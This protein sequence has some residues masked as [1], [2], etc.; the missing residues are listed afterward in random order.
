MAQL[1]A[2]AFRRAVAYER[3]VMN[4]YQ[5]ILAWINQ[6]CQ[7]AE[8]QY[9]ITLIPVT[10]T[11]SLGGITDPNTGLGYVDIFTLFNTKYPSAAPFYVANCLFGT[12]AWT[13]QQL[14]QSALG[15][16]AQ[17]TGTAFPSPL[18]PSVPQVPVAAPTTSPVG[19]LLGDGTAR[20]TNLA[21]SLYPIGAIT[22]QNGVPADSR[23][24]FV[25]AGIQTPFGT[26]LWWVLSSPPASAVGEYQ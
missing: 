5:Q 15:Y 9:G 26:A 2:A 14:L 4:I 6:A 25:E 13:P 21:G 7:E 12:F 18:P 23:G 22:G 17:V 20:Y 11:L 24:T 19:A 16:F 3:N 1:K 8:L 10:Q